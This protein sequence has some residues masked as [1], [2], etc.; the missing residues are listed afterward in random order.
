MPSSLTVRMGGHG[1]LARPTAAAATASAI[2]AGPNPKP[3]AGAATATGAAYVAGPSTGF[4]FYGPGIAGDAL[5]NTRVGFTAATNVSFDRFVAQY[6]GSLTNVVLYFLSADAPGYGAGTGGT[7]K[8]D[9]YATNASGEPTGSALATQIV[10]AN[11]VSDTDLSVTFGTPYTVTAGTRYA[12]VYTNTD[13][14]PTTNY[15]SLDRWFLGDG[16]SAYFSA[17][18]PVP[19]YAS[20][21]YA[22]GYAST[23]SGPWTMRAGFLP[24]MDLTIGGNHQGMSYGEASYAT[25]QVGEINGSNKMVRQRF[26]PTSSFTATGIGIRLLKL[27]GTTAD[28]TAGLYSGSTLLGSVTIAASSVPSGL[29]PDGTSSATGLGYSSRWVEATFSSSISVTSGTAHYVRLSSTGGTYYAWVMRR[30]ADS[31]LYTAATGFAD[32]YAEKTTDGTTW[33]SLGRVSAENDLQFFLRK[34]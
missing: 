4:S 10:A 8:V 34:P 16:S 19:A 24:I 15:F 1:S 26:T 11:A 28:L 29:A 25:G 17:S 2:L 22:H 33:S 20:D 18:R 30:L 31:Y 5:A 27:T 32:G 13:A 21:D 14:S 7:W 3:S 23:V 12:L 6:S 9:L